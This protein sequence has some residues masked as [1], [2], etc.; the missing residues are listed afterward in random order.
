MVPTRATVHS[1]TRQFI[2]YS[3]SSAH[4]TCGRSTGTPRPDT[5]SMGL[6]YSN[7]I[8]SLSSEQHDIDISNSCYYLSQITEQN[9]FK[10]NRQQ[11]K[12][13]LK[14][15]NLYHLYTLQAIQ[16]CRKGKDLLKLNTKDFDYNN[17]IEKLFRYNIIMIIRQSLTKEI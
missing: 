15:K 8:S 7:G 13:W 16:N 10:W 9:P 5:E 12:L 14:H 2:L 3:H 6:D 1:H 11:I 4:D 17:S